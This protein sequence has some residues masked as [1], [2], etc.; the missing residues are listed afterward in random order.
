[1]AGLNIQGLYLDNTTTADASA[2]ITA[3]HWRVYT[4]SDGVYAV[5]SAGVEVKLNNYSDLVSYVNGVSGDLAAVDQYL[6][7]EIDALTFG[8]T[9]IVTYTNAT[10]VPVTLGGISAGST[11]TSASMQYMFDKLLY[12]YQYPAFTAFAIQSQAT[13]LEV[14]DSIAANK[15]F[16]WATSHSANV[17]ANSISITDQTASV[18]IATGLANT[19]TYAST[20]GA[21]TKTAAGSNTFLIQGSN[22]LA[23]SFSATETVS[24][25]WRVFHGESANA[26]P[27]LEADIEALGSSPLQAGFAGT[28][29]FA[30]SGYKYIA[31]PAVY[32]TATQFKDQLTNFNVAMSPVYTV[33]VTNSFGPSTT[34]NVHR[35]TNVLGS[36]INIVVA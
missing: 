19:G 24:W 13:T 12:P 10:P 14:G 34:Y 3:G 17:A 2:G 35:T 21:V 36:S 4:K 26:G 18:S 5:D 11:F 7:S 25:V 23:G 28:Y 31:Y 6:Q 8:V 33:S 16:N 29:S 27:L 30:A 32:G 20:Y 9:G 22:S 15:T 1:M